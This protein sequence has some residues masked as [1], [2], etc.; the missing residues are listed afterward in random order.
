MVDEGQRTTLSVSALVITFVFVGVGLP[1]W[2]TTT[3]VYR[4]DLP[5]VAISELATIKPNYRVNITI[6]IP[7]PD[8]TMAS[9]TAVTRQLLDL[10]TDKNMLDTGQIH[11]NPGYTVATRPAKAN[12]L[13]ILQI[14][15][16]SIEELD[17]KICHS[18]ESQPGNY[19]V[20]QLPRIVD[21]NSNSR[22]LVYLGQHRCVYITSGSLVDAL[23]HVSEI[24]AR[25]IVNTDIVSAAYVAATDNQRIEKVVYFNMCSHHLA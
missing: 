24:F 16:N 3:S 19:L 13:Q 20:Y 18:A 10:L 21:L 4:A 11:P 22:H 7:D 12:E 23:P 17:E 9:R 15:H 5:L 25:V 14:S 1:M 6:I 8:M 2:W